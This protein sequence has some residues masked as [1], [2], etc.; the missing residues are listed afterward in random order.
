MSPREII[1]GQTRQPISAEVLERKSQRPAKNLREFIPD[2][3]NHSRR[4]RV[5]IIRKKLVE[6]PLARLWT[7]YPGHHLLR[8]T[9]GRTETQPRSTL[10]T[11][12]KLGMFMVS[13]GHQVCRE[14]RQ[15]QPSRRICGCSSFAGILNIEPRNT[16]VFTRKAIKAHLVSDVMSMCQTV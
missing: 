15:R 16:I 1:L 12:Q 6:S 7:R 4:P 8:D 5:R 14:I 13:C 11:D 10:G 3:V 9:N 2:R